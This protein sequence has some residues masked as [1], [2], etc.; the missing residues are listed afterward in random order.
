VIRNA[1]IFPD[2]LTLCVTKQTV[3]GLQYL[4]SQNI[5][6]RDIK[7]ANILLTMDGNVKITDFGVSKQLQGDHL[8]QNLFASPFLT[9]NVF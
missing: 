3:L 7:A 6:H 1:G 8:I 4:H 2:E 5:I 9:L